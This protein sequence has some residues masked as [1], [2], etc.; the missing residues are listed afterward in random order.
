MTCPEGKLFGLH[1]PARDEKKMLRHHCDKIVDIPTTMNVLAPPSPSA[2]FVGR[3]GHATPSRATPSHAKPRHATPPSAF[4]SSSQ[5][6]RCWRNGTMYKAQPR[7]GGGSDSG[8]G[9]RRREERVN[10]REVRLCVLYTVH[11]AP[12]FWW[13]WCWR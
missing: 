13:L 5:C 3:S 4:H 11:E 10:G 8:K 6:S 9:L 2:P 12:L 1:N 7:Q